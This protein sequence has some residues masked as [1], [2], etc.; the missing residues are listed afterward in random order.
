FSQH[1]LLRASG[2]EG[3]SF[4]ERFANLIRERERDTGTLAH[5]TSLELQPHFKEE[6][7]FKDQPL[8]RGR[9]LI[10][11]SDERFAFRRKMH[12]SKSRPP[13][14]QLQTARDRGRNAIGNIRGQVFQC[15]M[16]DAP[17]PARRKFGIG[18]RLIDGHDTADFKRFNVFGGFQVKLVFATSSIQEFKLRLGDLKAATFPALFHLAIESHELAGL[19]TITQVFTMEPDAFQSGASL[20]RDQLK[21][22]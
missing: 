13:V 4:L 14:K 1:T 20:A 3:K 22:G 2:L 18:G 6:Q 19:E 15:A 21:D 10:L 12:L 17:E 11:Q 8:M 16:N 5:F 9:G 7:L